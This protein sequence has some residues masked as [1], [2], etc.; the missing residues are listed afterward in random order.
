MKGGTVCS[1]TLSDPTGAI[2]Y[3]NEFVD[4]AKE[5]LLIHTKDINEG[6][7]LLTLSDGQSVHVQKIIVE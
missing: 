5:D 1:V 2:Y 3:S 6:I 4:F 7:Y